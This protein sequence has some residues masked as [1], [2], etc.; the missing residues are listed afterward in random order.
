MTTIEPAFLECMRKLC[1][2]IAS[3]ALI[4][5]ATPVGRKNPSAVSQKH[6]SPT[7]TIIFQARMPLAKI[8]SAKKPLF[9][10]LPKSFSSILAYQSLLHL[11][12]R[13]F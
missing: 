13:T 10:H 2:A 3:I 5:D 8:V 12:L 1:N 7:A 6:T 9:S 4:K 11:P